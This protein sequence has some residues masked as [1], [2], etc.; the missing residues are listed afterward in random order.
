MKPVII[1]SYFRSGSSIIWKII[2]E[3]NPGAVVYYEP[4]HS[5]IIKKSKEAGNDS[6]HGMVLWEE[7]SGFSEDLF[8]VH[9]YLSEGF[10]RSYLGLGDYGD[11]LCEKA[12][13]ESKKP[14]L[15]T[16]RWHYFTPYFS[17]RGYDVMQL[18]RHPY[19]VINSIYGLAFKSDNNIPYVIKK[20][21]LSLGLVD[22][23]EQQQFFEYVTSVSSTSSLPGKSKKILNIKLGF[24]DKVLFSW[25]KANT[26]V[27]RN[28]EGKSGFSVVSYDKL[29]SGDPEEIEK[30]RRHSLNFSSTSLSS[31]GS[32]M[33][34]DEAVLKR[35]DKLGIYDEC[36]GLI[37]QIR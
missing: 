37:S 9:P 19:D 18:I 17:D 8:K 24:K 5:H 15:Q 13:E 21:F 32:R 6:L 4:C 3:E 28:C 16:N 36:L 34:K 29:C 12:Y 2:K 7:Y 22:H 26:F 20:I 27:L 14:V 33:E 35:A 10:P 31:R 30:F 11:F 25:V 1:N 23:F